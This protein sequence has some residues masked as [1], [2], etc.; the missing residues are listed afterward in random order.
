MRMVSYRCRLYPDTYKKPYFDDTSWVSQYHRIGRERDAGEY[1]LLLQKTH[2]IDVWIL[3][4]WESDTS[5]LSGLDPSTNPQTDLG[6]LRPKTDTSAP[7]KRP[8]TT[9]RKKQAKAPGLSG[10]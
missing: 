3:S 4:K 8:R 6:H 7:T 10:E 1:I 2:R 5:G 9:S